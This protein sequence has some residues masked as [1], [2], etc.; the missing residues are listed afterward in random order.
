MT[1]D[2]H[3][4]IQQVAAEILAQ[5]GDEA[6]PYFFLALAQYL[7]LGG[8]FPDLPHAVEPLWVHF[9]GPLGADGV[10]VVPDDRRDQIGRLVEFLVALGDAWA[11]LGPSLQPQGGQAPRTPLEAVQSILPGASP[12]S[13]PYILLLLGFL[14]MPQTNLSV[15]EIIGMLEQMCSAQLMPSLSHPDR[16]FARFQAGAIAQQIVDIGGAAGGGGGAAAAA[17][18]AAPAAPA[19]PPQA[20]QVYHCPGCQVPC[21]PGARQCEAC[22]QILGPAV[23]P[24]PQG[25]LRAVEA[26]GH[27]LP[28]LLRSS[29][30]TV[31]AALLGVT[32]E[33]GG[34]GRIV[35]VT[36]DAASVYVIPESP[37]PEGQVTAAYSQLSVRA[38]IVAGSVVE[39]SV[40]SELAGEPPAPRLTSLVLRPHP[41]ALG[42]HGAE[43]AGAR[44]QNALALAHNLHPIEEAL[45]TRYHVVNK[46]QIL[47]IDGCGWMGAADA[48]FTVVRIGTDRPDDDAPYAYTLAEGHAGGEVHQVEIDILMSDEDAATHQNLQDQHDAVQAA[49]EAALALQTEVRGWLARNLLRRMLQEQAQAVV[50]EDQLAEAERECGDAEGGSTTIRVRLPDGRL[51]TLNFRPGTTVAQ[52]IYCLVAKHGVAPPQPGGGYAL[53]LPPQRGQPAGNLPPATQIVGRNT[54]HLAPTP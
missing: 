8:V 26:T 12:Q 45:E 17:A 15:G 42:P 7:G 25:G 52:V 31:P 24:S 34:A 49:T 27:E 33:L 38:P 46:G 47:A 11:N 19:P 51:L 48:Y 32:A 20:P 21:P 50:A 5:T 53:R 28:P 39:A 40:V 41:G 14:V 2:G 3:P 1:Q 36:S 10:P 22:F 18:V 44:E 54:Y 6:A 9:I 29:R 30:A 4:P 35:K 43:H 23:W 13:L 37:G 16:A